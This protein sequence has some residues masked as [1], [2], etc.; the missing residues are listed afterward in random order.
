M[1]ARNSGTN[2]LQRVVNGASP[3]QEKLS[4]EYRPG[5]TTGPPL[6][7]RICESCPDSYLPISDARIVRYSRSANLK[8]LGGRPRVRATL[9]VSST[10]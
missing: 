9:F 6:L 5:L 7:V 8:S 4:L 10:E 2:W 3:E 1:N